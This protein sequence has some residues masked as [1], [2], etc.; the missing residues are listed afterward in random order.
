[1]NDL[2][3]K[4]F[5]SYSRQDFYVAEEVYA[6]LLGKDVDVWM[7]A[8]EINPGDTWLDNLSRAIQEADTVLFVAT[9]RSVRATM[10]QVELGLA[11]HFGTPV[12]VLVAQPCDLDAVA[13]TR[14][15]FRARVSKRSPVVPVVL[16]ALAFTALCFLGLA[17]HYLWTSVTDHS[18]QHL[19]AKWSAVPVLRSDFHLVLV[20]GCL[21]ATG[22]I[23]ACATALL[24]RSWR[25]SYLLPLFAVCAVLQ[26]I[27]HYAGP[28]GG[29]LRVAVFADAVVA[30]VLLVLLLGSTSVLRRSQTGSGSVVA[31]W[32]ILRRA[33]E[34]NV[35]AAVQSLLGDHVPFELD[36]L[37]ALL[38]PAP[39]GRTF[40]VVHEAADAPLAARISEVCRTVGLIDAPVPARA[41]Q[42]LLLVSNTTDVA[43][44][45]RNEAGGLGI[46]VLACSLDRVTDSDLMQR[47]WVDFRN[48]ELNL[49]E[50]A[51]VT[52]RPPKRESRTRTFVPVP[53]GTCR[54]PLAIAADVRALIL[55]ALSSTLVVLSNT[56]W[57]IL[58]A[59]T[60]T[61]RLVLAM[62]IAVVTADVVRLIVQRKASPRQ[63]RRE[64]LL[65]AAMS[66]AFA[67]VTGLDP[68]L[69]F[70]HK[71]LTAA[72]AAWF[73]TD[74]FVRDRDLEA[75]LPAT[76]VPSAPPALGFPLTLSTLVISP[77][78]YA[79]LMLAAATTLVS[80]L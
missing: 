43:Q 57:N 39:R 72:I 36:E 60:N 37:S 23:I 7:D 40:T 53:A 47:Q 30:V 17:V 41:D 26:V 59:Q 71:I 21:A 56:Y 74:P 70:G 55:V 19:D 66:L 22:V 45:H 13:D 58:G 8:A 35:F 5:L 9:P 42:R 61:A 25:W 77:W 15:R 4:V 68:A 28:S 65:L 76:P 20:F 18:G 62:G 12:H 27:N 11:A 69:W 75:W 2:G 50:I 10:V 80:P 49:R 73:V 44:L 31:R 46:P 78:C 29:L 51:Q 52:G 64:Q 54:L 33:G 38:E 48:D 14:P 6:D 34:K 63:L 67:V 24:R 79:M 32:M 1:M 3:G 16:A